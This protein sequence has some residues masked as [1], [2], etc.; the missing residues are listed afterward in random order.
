[1]ALE[2]LQFFSVTMILIALYLIGCELYG[3]PF[4]LHLSSKALSFFTLAAYAV[5]VLTPTAFYAFVPW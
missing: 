5:L 4:L 1:M 2:K 3:T